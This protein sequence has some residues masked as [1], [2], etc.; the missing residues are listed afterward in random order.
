MNSPVFGGQVPSFWASARMRS[1]SARSWYGHTCITWFSGP[2]S[3]CQKA[4]SSECFFRFSYA[5]PKRFSN[6]SWVRGLRS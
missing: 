4:K 3:V 6:S 5:S 1:R 2:T